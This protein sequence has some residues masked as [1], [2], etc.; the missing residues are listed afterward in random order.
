MPA[1][2]LL[3]EMTREQIREVAPRAIAILPTASTEQHGPHL[4]VCTDATICEAVC[5]LAAERASAEVS[6]VVAPTVVFG[7]SDHHRPYPG[8][9]SLPSV[10]FIQVVSDVAIGLIASGFRKIAIVNGHGGNDEAVRIV[11]RDLAN[12][13]PVAAAATSYWLLAQSVGVVA[14]ARGAGPVP[15]HAGHFE[16][17]LMLALRPDLVDGR[18]EAGAGRSDPQLRP[19]ATIARAGARIG[20]GPGHTDDASGASADLGRRLLDAIVGEVAAFLR[21]FAGA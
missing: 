13:Y 19:G 21:D 10:T 1:R 8:V 7:I 4:P 3:A 2:L 20:D 5:R 15:G 6:A 12:A 14:E 9:L 17:S 16:T 18:P 11:A